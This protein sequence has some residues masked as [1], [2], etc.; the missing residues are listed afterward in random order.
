MKGEMEM[1]GGD[2]EKRCRVGVSPTMMVD[3]GGPQ[4]HPTCLECRDLGSKDSGI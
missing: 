3:S 1:N 2:G 4:A